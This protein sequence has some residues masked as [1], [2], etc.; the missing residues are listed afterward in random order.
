M[1]RALWT[2]ISSV[3]CALCWMSAAQAADIVIVA[4]ER[5]PGYEAAAQ[6]V[7]S[8]LARKGPARWEIS[9]LIASELEG[10]DVGGAAAPKL[11][12]VLG[13]DALRQVLARDPRVPV[14]AALIPR[15]GYER[16]LREL[17]RKP[18]A[19][20]SAVYLDQPFGRRLDLLRLAIPG[21]QRVGVL[22][23][24]ESVLQ[25]PLLA[26]ALQARNMQE[27]SGAIVVGGSLFT[28]L[29][30]ALD[31]ADVVLAVAD[32]QV[33]NSTTISNILLTT[34]RARV[35]VLAFSPAYVKAGALLSVQ[36]SPAQIGTQAGAIAR[37]VLQGGALPPAQ[38][39]VEF[40]VSVNDHVARSLG[41]T[42]DEDALTDRLRRLE[43]RP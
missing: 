3:L 31:G 33:F 27:L 12:I 36:T 40:S 7:V 38:Y 14:L 6:G 37:S 13:M 2:F 28:G 15:S 41:L 18:S 42:L 25:Q 39:P 11:F 30:E 23:G 34:Y 9:K 4:S 35:P 19:Q 10:I 16:V 5:S 21:A 32:P 20:V 8:E 43:K 22:W 17:G 24:P 26:S 29:K 1:L